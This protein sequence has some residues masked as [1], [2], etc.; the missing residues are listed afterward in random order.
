METKEMKSRTKTASNLSEEIKQSSSI[1][2]EE[3]LKDT[4]SFSEFKTIFAKKMNE[5]INTNLCI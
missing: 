5:R 2:R 3:F 1:S 4:I